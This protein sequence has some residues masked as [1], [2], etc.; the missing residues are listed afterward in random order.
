MTIYKMDFLSFQ[1]LSLCLE[2]NASASE[3]KGQ[4]TTISLSFLIICHSSFQFTLSSELGIP[5]WITSKA[6]QKE[7][8]EG[9]QGISFPGFS[10][11]GG[12]AVSWAGWVPPMNLTAPPEKDIPTGLSPSRSGY[13][14]SPHLEVDR[15]CQDIHDS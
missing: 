5:I 4:A 15:A 8:G 1:I 12:G 6:E 2:T 9:G 7:E 14:P 13:V 10:R 3:G 11:A